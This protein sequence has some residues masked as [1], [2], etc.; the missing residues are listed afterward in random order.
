[1]VSSWD[2]SACLQVAEEALG[3]G[4]KLLSVVPDGGHAGIILGLI[5]V[6][7]IVHLVA[8]ALRSP[9]ARISITN[10]IAWQQPCNFS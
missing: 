4:V 8:R 5:L 2:M 3:L 7:H 1:M 6:Q 9:R 10:F